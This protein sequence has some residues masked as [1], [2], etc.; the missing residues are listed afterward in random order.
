MDIWVSE[1]VGFFC[2]FVFCCF[3]RVLLRN[4]FAPNVSHSCVM[5]VKISIPSKENLIDIGPATGKALGQA[6]GMAQGVRE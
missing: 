6:V 2:L 1:N 4:I 3:F 5:L